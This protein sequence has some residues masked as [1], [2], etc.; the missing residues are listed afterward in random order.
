MSRKVLILVNPKA[1]KAKIKKDIQEIEENLKRLNYGVVTKY[2]TKRVN[3]TEVIR[4]YDD[5]YDILIVCGGDGTL[6]EATQ[7]LYEMKKK[8][9][10]GFIPTGTTNDFAK[11]LKVSFNKM[12]IST[13]INKYNYEK[14]DQGLFNERVF[15]YSATFGVFS[16]VSYRTSTKWK[17]KVGRL[18]YLGS[19]TKE[20]FNI[21]PYKMNV[22]TDEKNIEDEF[23]F[24]SV[25]N[26]NYIGGFNMFKDEEIKLNDGKFEV[27]LVKK[28]Q[29]ILDTAKAAIKII[30]GNFE[31]ENIYYFKTS[32]I[33]MESEEQIDWSLDGE[34]GGKKDKVKIY[35][36]KES[37]EYIMPIKMKTK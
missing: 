9:F 1:G 22:Y 36:M 13:N 21:K 16:K 19:A 24:G 26:S 5:D 14:V 11:S 28:P 18:A 37:I 27:V 8:V 29:N 12:D 32:K 33:E 3:G 7:G 10:V 25:S 6:N 2:T 4:N 17:N 34:F 30:N 20:I 23:I 15:N 35:N 31:D